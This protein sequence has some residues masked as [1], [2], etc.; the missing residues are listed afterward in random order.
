MSNNNKGNGDATQ[1]C[2]HLIEVAIPSRNALCTITYQAKSVART[3]AVALYARTE[4][5]EEATVTIDLNDPSIH[6]FLKVM[7]SR[8]LGAAGYLNGVVYS[9]RA[10]RILSELDD[11]AH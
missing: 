5:D 11:T 2:L 6:T 3:N 9:F 10:G 1:A 7:A 4:Y 8:G